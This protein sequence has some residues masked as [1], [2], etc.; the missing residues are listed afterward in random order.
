ME[1][2]F[3]YNY[4]IERIFFAYFSIFI[5]IIFMNKKL[6]YIYELEKKY[7]NLDNSTIDTGILSSGPSKETYTF[8]EIDIK[9]NN[10]IN[11]EQKFSGDYIY[12]KQHVINENLSLFNYSP[13]NSNVIFTSGSGSGSTLT[14][15]NTLT[16]LEKKLLINYRSQQY[17]RYN[18]YVYYGIKN[19]IKVTKINDIFVLDHYDDIKS[20][21]K[22]QILLKKVRIFGLSFFAFLFC[23][24]ILNI[25]FENV[26]INSFE[27]QTS[28]FNS[29]RL[30]EFFSN[31]R[32]FLNL[33]YN[34]RYFS[35]PIISLFLVLILY[36]IS[37]INR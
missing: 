32:S 20:V 25:A 11:I 26:A 37:F 18:N 10:Q 36:L 1:C 19:N 5:I 17:N 31:K 9:N 12:I 4:I 6:N 24:M 29:I 2:Q 30:F 21:I 35:Y 15:L 28:F 3:N 23:M 22:K 7:K 13:L 14:D 16:N 33:I 27:C 34:K 8:T